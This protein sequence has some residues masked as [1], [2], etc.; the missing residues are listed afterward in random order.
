MDGE[1]EQVS[2]VRVA[3][4]IPAPRSTALRN[5]LKKI[6]DQWPLVLVV[7]GG[8][9]TVIWLAVLVWLPFRLLQI[10]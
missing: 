7:F 1:V 8:V 2:R 10:L 9:L 3:L 4:A 6:I 5:K